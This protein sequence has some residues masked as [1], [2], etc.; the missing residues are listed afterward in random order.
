MRHEIEQRLLRPLGLACGWRGVTRGGGHSWR[1]TL[2][3]AR[4]ALL[5]VGLHK[6]YVWED[7]PTEG[8]HRQPTASAI[9]G[10][11]VRH[12]EEGKL[13]LHLRRIA[14]RTGIYVVRGMVLREG[15]EMV[16]LRLL[17]ADGPKVVTMRHGH[18]LRSPA[19]NAVGEMV[20]DRRHAKALGLL[21]AE[22]EGEVQRG[23]LRQALGLGS[24]GC[25]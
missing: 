12:V 11:Y 14:E 20:L 22:R 7:V 8:L 4:E 1:I 2:A 15:L 25:V 10:T 5:C 13:L 9:T 23:A 16:K 19:Y 6:T 17:L 21:E 18:I 24:E 3:P